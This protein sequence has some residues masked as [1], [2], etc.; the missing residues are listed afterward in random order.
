MANLPDSSWTEPFSTAKPVYPYNNVKQTRGGHLFEM[1]D[2]PNAQRIRLQHGTAN[3]FIEWQGDGT[4]IT[5]IFGDGYNITM[6]NNNVYIGG[7]CNIT[8]VGPSVLHVK[9][10][11]WVQ[12]DGDV[13]MNVGGDCITNVGGTAEVI[14][15]GDI[16]LSSQGTVTVS[17]DAVN[18]QSDLT[19]NGSISALGSV[20]S[21]GS[22]TTLGAVAAGLQA[23]NPALVEI[24]RAHV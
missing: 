6:A 2:T 5:K 10:D 22:V 7:Q 20:F 11:S 3:N 1:D 15:G 23:L 12:V 8:I 14:A 16:D 17:A 13:N 9:G 19:V 4:A 21:T 18:I 24:G